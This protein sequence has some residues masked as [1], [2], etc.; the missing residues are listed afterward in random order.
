[1]HGP[2]AERHLDGL[3]ILHFLPMVTAPVHRE[4]AK[5]FD[6]NRESWSQSRDGYIGTP[7][8]NGGKTPVRPLKMGGCSQ[9]VAIAGFALSQSE[10]SAHPREPECRRPSG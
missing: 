9:R 1:M 10:L 3:L 8:P 4:R 6:R 5:V 7:V 2:D